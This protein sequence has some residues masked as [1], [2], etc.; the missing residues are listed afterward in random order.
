MT[1]KCLQRWPHLTSRCQKTIRQ[2]TWVNFSAKTL[3]LS[4]KTTTLPYFRSKLTKRNASESGRPNSTNLMSKILKRSEGVSVKKYASITVKI[5]CLQIFSQMIKKLSYRTLLCSHNVRLSWINWPSIQ[6]FRIQFTTKFRTCCTNLKS[7]S[8]STQWHHSWVRSAMS[9]IKPLTMLLNIKNRS[10][11]H[12][13]SISGNKFACLGSW[14]KMGLPISTATTAPH[15]SKKSYST[16]C[17]QILCY[18]KIITRT[19]SPWKKNLQ[20]KKHST[21]N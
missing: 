13:H 4:A 18:L 12:S 7:G 19:N 15:K 3:Q 14:G 17:R 20:T 5:W 11:T 16:V 6:L 9:S 1:L 2:S 21:S 10:L 8:S